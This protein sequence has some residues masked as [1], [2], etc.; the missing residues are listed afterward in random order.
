MV[1]ASWSAKVDGVC[2]VFE[3]VAEDVDLTLRKWASSSRGTVVKEGSRSNR[4]ISAL[5]VN[6]KWLRFLCCREDPAFYIQRD[7]TQ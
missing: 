4:E 6:S 5:S 3:K 1:L 2:N 7:D